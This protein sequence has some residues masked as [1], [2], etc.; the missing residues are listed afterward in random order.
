MKDKTLELCCDILAERVIKLEE[1]LM[2]QKLVNSMLE[3]RIK[4]Y[5]TE[6]EA[7]KNA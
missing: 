6:K 2:Y 4:L 5:Q 3:D 7:S 1:E